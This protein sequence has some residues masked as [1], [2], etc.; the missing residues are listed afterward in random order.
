MVLDSDTVSEKAHTRIQ[1]EI[2]K[3]LTNILAN[4]LNY[5]TSLISLDL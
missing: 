1:I 5:C 4:N 2:L 3:Y